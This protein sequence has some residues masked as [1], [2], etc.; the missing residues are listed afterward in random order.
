MRLRYAGTCRQCGQALAAGSSALYNGANKT[1]TCVICVPSGPDEAIVESGT[2]GA[3]AQREFERRKAKRETRIREAHPRLGGLML[4]LS[5]GPQS[6]RSWATG[7]R[8][9]VVLG[10]RLDK[11]VDRGLHVL[12]DRV[13]PG[14]KANIDHIVIGHRGVFVIDA[15]RYK[16]APRL[17]VEGGLFRPRTSKLMVGSRDCTRLVGGV[18]KQIADVVSALEGAGL[19]EMP[20]FGMLCFVEADWPLLGGD[21]E[22]G[23]LDVLWPAKAVARVTQPGP[24]DA[25]ANS[26]AYRA[27]AA[28]FPQA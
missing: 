25:D 24:V 13:I 10:R 1:V 5:D 20:V 17:Q 2:A 21:F 15:K 16:G 12:H 6:T 22:I 3:S 9:E 8:G 11:L 28:H 27:L 14:T 4:A 7:A 19:G 26:A 18:H 23:G